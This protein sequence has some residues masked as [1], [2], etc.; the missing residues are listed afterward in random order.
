MENKKQKY[1]P[2]AKYDKIHCRSIHLKLNLKTDKDILDYL[3]STGNKQ[4]TVK[5]AIR[6]YMG[7]K[8]NKKNT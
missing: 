5:E 7:G 6:M 4:G 8:K 1:A 2:Q 3:D